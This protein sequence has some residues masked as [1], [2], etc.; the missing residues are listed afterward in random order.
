MDEREAGQKDEA[1]RGG[2]GGSWAF[3]QTGGMQR[4]MRKRCCLVSETAAALVGGGRI[5]RPPPS[6]SHHTA[7]A[8]EEAKLVVVG[9]DGLMGE[10]GDLGAPMF[11]R[12]YVVRTGGK[13][14]TLQNK[15]LIFLN[16]ICTR[17]MSM[18]EH[19]QS[20]LNLSSWE[21]QPCGSS[22]GLHANSSLDPE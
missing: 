5:K 6:P 16:K 9:N 13:P 10:S 3:R 21:M 18:L 19:S 8:A 11:R 2:G 22:L 12:K 15:A 14:W 20:F 4:R 17:T 7:A 1:G